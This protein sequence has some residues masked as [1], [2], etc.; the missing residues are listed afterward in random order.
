MTLLEIKEM[1][2]NKMIDGMHITFDNNTYGDDD[3]I[4]IF[5]S[6]ANDE[7]WMKQKAVMDDMVKTLTED[8]FVISL[9]SI[10]VLQVDG[11]KSGTQSI[12]LRRSKNETN[13]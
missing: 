12:I 10:D 3:R 7:L 4:S 11:R 5:G 2:V 8:K 6:G 1:L 13:I 9:N